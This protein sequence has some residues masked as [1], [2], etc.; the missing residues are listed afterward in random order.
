[1]SEP[2]PSEFQMDESCWACGGNQSCAN[3]SDLR[4]FDFLFLASNRLR[5]TAVLLRFSL[6]L[7]PSTSKGGGVD[8][9]VVFAF[10]LSNHLLIMIYNSHGW[11]HY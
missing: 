6:F 8:E 5:R 4:R 9:I 3:V 1:M 10:F 7:F 11:H 2:N